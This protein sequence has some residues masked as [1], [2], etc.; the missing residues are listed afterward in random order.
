MKKYKL[1]GFTGTSIGM[2]TPQKVVLAGVLTDIRDAKAE[3]HHGACV[4]ADE[5]CAIVAHTLGF[6]C[7][8]H[9]GVTKNGDQWK[10][11]IKAVN[12][13]HSILPE[14]EFLKRNQD[15]VATVKILIAT[16]KERFE[17]LRSGT[18]ATIRYAKKVKI[19][20]IIILSNGK[21]TRV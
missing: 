1:I 15:I 14:D 4:G 13:S 3:L 11:S 17:V 8:A 7:V 9:P 10:R 16:P 20:V 6:K 21:V 5:E 18:W 19:P 2:T 12:A